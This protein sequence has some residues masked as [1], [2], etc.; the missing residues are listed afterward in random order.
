M[1]ALAS[2]NTKTEL[3]HLG[4]VGNHLRSVRGDSS[5]HE[6]ATTIF[7][8]ACESVLRA[9]KAC[10]VV[11]GCNAVEA[12]GRLMIEVLDEG[13]LVGPNSRRVEYVTALI[14]KALQVHAPLVGIECAR[15]YLR[16]GGKLSAPTILCSICGATRVASGPA[17]VDLIFHFAK[18]VLEGGLVP[19]SSSKTVGVYNVLLAACGEPVPTRGRVGNRY[20]DADALDVADRL[21]SASGLALA[22]MRADVPFT[23]HVNQ[24]RMNLLLRAICSASL[25]LEVA[26]VRAWEDLS[27]KELVALRR[28]VGVDSTLQSFVR[29]SP[30]VFDVRSRMQALVS[31]ALILAE[32][33]LGVMKEADHS[34]P[35]RYEIRGSTINLLSNAAF[36]SHTL[37]VEEG[38]QL[39]SVL[40]MSLELDRVRRKLYSRA[41]ENAVL[42]AI[43]SAHGLDAAP[44]LFGRITSTFA[45]AMRRG[46]TFQRSIMER[47]WDL[48]SCIPSGQ[49]I[50]DAV[51]SDRDYIQERLQRLQ[52]EPR[53]RVAAAREQLG[54]LKGGISSSDG[55]FLKS[56]AQ[57]SERSR[58]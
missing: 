52:Q 46:F 28:E 50:P 39:M 55:P 9:A 6:S 49:Q 45:H 37:T 13:V 7:L 17:D 21:L 31:R 35:L 27:Q 19:S 29:E 10:A 20:R 3:A 40:S 57:L 24:G 33:A 12:V 54:Q 34:K 5:V 48:C 23:N 4:A 41:I 32:V 16:L 25:L 8:N 26:Q 56:F 53:P 58:L 51:L 22:V 43:S 2:E 15:T 36:F 18:E 42:A 14:V 30:S 44:E 11:D 38:Q 47:V 1:L